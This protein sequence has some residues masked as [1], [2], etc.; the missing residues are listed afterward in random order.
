MHG[1]IIFAIGEHYLT[2]IC[3]ETQVKK[4]ELVRHTAKGKIRNC[5][6]KRYKHAKEVNYDGNR[7]TI[8]LQ[9]FVQPP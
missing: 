1:F 3:M 4:Q 5:V 2:C 7:S 9:Q 8:S 6:I